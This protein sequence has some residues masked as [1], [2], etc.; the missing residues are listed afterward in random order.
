MVWQKLQSQLCSCPEDA[1]VSSFEETEKAETPA[2]GLGETEKADMGEDRE[3][4]W[5]LWEDTGRA[6]GR[7]RNESEK[8]WGRGN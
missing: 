5:P 7:L 4:T 8:G 3:R 1:G 6:G 2:H